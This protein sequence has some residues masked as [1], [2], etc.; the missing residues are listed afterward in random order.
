[1]L[2]LRFPIIYE[3]LAD[4]PLFNTELVCQFFNSFLVFL[5]LEIH[6]LVPKQIHALLDTLEE[7][8][9]RVGDTLP[10]LVSSVLLFRLLNVQLLFLLNHDDQVFDDR[11]QLPTLVL[12]KVLLY[13]LQVD[14]IHHVDEISRIL[15][16]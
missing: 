6:F 3:E 8:Q 11:P 7:H 5:W 10:F 1:M 13:C 16:V 9:V 2:G 15:E 14:V 12:F 4:N